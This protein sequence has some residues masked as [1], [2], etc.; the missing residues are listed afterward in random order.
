MPVEKLENG[1]WP[2]PA[3]LPLGG[4]WSGHCTAPGHDAETPSHHVLE[5]CCN[6]G[7]A[8]GCGWVPRD[9]AWDAVRFGVMAPAG[10]DRLRKAGN[11]QPASEIR[12][13]YVC[14]RNHLPAASG[15]LQFDLAQSAWCRRIDDSRLQKMAECFLEAYLSRRS[16][17]KCSQEEPIFARGTTND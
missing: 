7:Y 10:A 1:A 2:H 13:R 3:R 16:P 6:L 15:E 12:L 4:G 5:N 14:E 11:G 17:A 8:N 9:R